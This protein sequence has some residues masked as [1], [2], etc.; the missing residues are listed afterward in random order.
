MHHFHTLGDSE[1]SR[2]DLCLADS[3]TTHTILT[4]KKYFLKL[5]MLNVKVYRVLQTYLNDLIKQI[6]FCLEENKI[7]SQLIMHCSLV[8]Q[9]EIY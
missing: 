8:N 9:R 3:A 7:N 1:M 6:L 5:T 2:E 4:N